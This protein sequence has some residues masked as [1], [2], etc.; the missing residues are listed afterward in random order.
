ME[1]IRVLG[2]ERGYENGLNLPSCQSWEVMLY[3][4]VGEKVEEKEK[5]G[6]QTRGGD[7]IV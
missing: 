1:E 6:R 2:K 3:E 4:M 5:R 7:W